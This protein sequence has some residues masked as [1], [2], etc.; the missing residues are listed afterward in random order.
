MQRAGSGPHVQTFEAAHF[1]RSAEFLRDA[2]IHDL[3]LGEVFAHHYVFGLDVAVAGALRV[4]VAQRLHNHVDDL[5]REALV[6]ML[7]F[8]QDAR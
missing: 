8:L 1:A 7:A 4:H 6:Q 5:L 2:E 3:H